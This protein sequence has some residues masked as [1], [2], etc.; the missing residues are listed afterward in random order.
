M[1]DSKKRGLFS[2]IFGGG[3][4]CCCNTRIEEVPEETTEKQDGQRPPSCCSGENTVPEDASRTGSD[5][6][7]TMSEG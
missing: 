3:K 5:S 4:S 7:K 6:D 2:K 1:S